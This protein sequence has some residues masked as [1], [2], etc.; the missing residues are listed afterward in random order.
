MWVTR[1]SAPTDAR[2]SRPRVPVRP[3]DTRW[4]T[5]AHVASL[6]LRHTTPAPDPRSD[7]ANGYTF[8]RVGVRKENGMPRKS[9]VRQP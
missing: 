7:S 8:R 2:T 1:D 6:A 5:V 4:P 9:G 3:L